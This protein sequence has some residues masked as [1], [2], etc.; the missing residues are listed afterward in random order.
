MSVTSPHTFFSDI[1]MNFSSPAGHLALLTERSFGISHKLRTRIIVAAFII[2][3][4]RPDFFT[5]LGTIEPEF[6]SSGFCFLL[7]I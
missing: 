7:N 3:D 2:Q 1:E 6:L 5:G 4:F